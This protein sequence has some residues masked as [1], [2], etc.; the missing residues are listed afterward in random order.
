MYTLF[1]LLFFSFASAF[2]DA[3]PGIDPEGGRRLR[4]VGDEG[5]GSDP[6]GGRVTAQYTGCVDPNG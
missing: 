6:H 4:A 2:S 1:F 5:S 3:G